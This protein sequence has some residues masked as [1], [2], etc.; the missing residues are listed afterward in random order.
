MSGFE[1]DG[2]LIIQRA[3][4]AFRV[5]ESFDIIEDGQ[6]SGLM[7]WEVMVM[8]RF[9]FERAPERFHGGVVIAVACGTHAGKSF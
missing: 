6:V 2:G 4:E 7:G 3:V 1:V 5:I 9:G 8:E